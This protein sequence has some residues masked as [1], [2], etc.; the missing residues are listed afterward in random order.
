[1]P[2]GKLQT[3]QRV[4]RRH[5][6][7][8]AVGHDPHGLCPVHHIVKAEADDR[9]ELPLG[10][11]EAHIVQRDRLKGRAD[12][13]SV[14]HLGNLDEGH[15]AVPVNDLEESACRIVG[16]TAIVELAVEHMAVG[17]IG[18]HGATV[19]GGTFGEKEIGAG[20]G[21]GAEEHGCTEQAG[22]NDTGGF[23]IVCFIICCFFIYKS[24]C[25]DTTLFLYGRKKIFFSRRMS[26]SG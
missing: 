5:D 6:A 15:A 2:D 26:D 10:D 11:A 16:G 25:K 4:L 23:H 9:R 12:A 24:K 20:F 19:L 22:C 8:G 7:A 1:M 14:A 18:D 17:G 21:H 13:V 3:L